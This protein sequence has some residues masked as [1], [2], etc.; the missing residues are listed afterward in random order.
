MYGGFV[1]WLPTCNI[2]VIT[3]PSCTF[4][5]IETTTT[6]NLPQ[7]PASMP[8]NP[9]LH[10]SALL[11]PGISFDGGLSIPSDLQYLKGFIVAQIYVTLCL[12]V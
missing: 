8:E 6:G 5:V 10:D 12:D 3:Y 4:L 11:S 1:T 9:L 2:V 7:A